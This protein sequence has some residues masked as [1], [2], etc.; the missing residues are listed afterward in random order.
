MNVAITDTQSSR[1]CRRHCT[2]SQSAKHTHTDTMYALA[3]A[4]LG[5]HT[6]VGPSDTRS[7]NWYACTLAR[8]VIERAHT[9]S[10]DTFSGTWYALKFDGHTLNRSARVH[11]RRRRTRTHWHHRRHALTHRH[12]RRPQASPLSRTRAQASSSSHTRAQ[13]SPSSRTRVQAS[14]SSRTRV[15]ASPLSRTCTHSQLTLARIGAGGYCPTPSTEVDAHLRRPCQT[16]CRLNFHQH[17]TVA[18]SCSHRDH[19][20]KISPWS[21]IN[22]WSGPRVNSSRVP[23]QTFAV[24]TLRVCT[25]QPARL[26]TSL[27]QLR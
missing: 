21:N 9:R 18:I 26:M 19:T 7:S 22:P 3:P 13:T 1:C 23:I 4:I 14:P 8:H 10:P 11:I 15:Q 27:D 24:H 2:C 17:I 6:S 16:V 12:R 25:H 5:L 20:H